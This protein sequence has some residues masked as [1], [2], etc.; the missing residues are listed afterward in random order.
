MIN[1]TL[2]SAAKYFTNKQSLGAV[3]C[4]GMILT[5]CAPS[6]LLESTQKVSVK[7]KT[8][9]TVPESIPDPFEP[10]NRRIDKV[11]E[12]LA[13]G[14]IRPTTGAYRYIVPA[15]ARRSV[16]N[17]SRNITY[18]VRLVNNVL[19]GRWK[20]TGD[21]SLRFITNSTVGI[22]FKQVGVAT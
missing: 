17:F 22:G 4:I 18:P 21:E 6:P 1:S 8:A 15:P 13:V 5:G 19:Q 3:F 11:N 2:I 12:K 20:G 14:V 9:A 10:V 16:T 7:Q